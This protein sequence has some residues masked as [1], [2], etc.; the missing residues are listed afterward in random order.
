MV[1]MKVRAGR[2]AGL[3]LA[4]LAVAALSACAS[5]G[6]L[7]FENGGPGTVVVELGDQEPSVIDTHG[8]VSYLDYDCT[9]GDVTIRFEDGSSTV[10]PGPLCSDK[11]VFIKDGAATVKP[12]EKNS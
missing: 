7:S 1:A 12:A 5:K 3:A 10:I 11:Q 6:K 2:A 9:P 4:V 8:G